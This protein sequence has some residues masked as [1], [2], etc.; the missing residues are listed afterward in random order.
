MLSVCISIICFKGWWFTTAN[1]FNYSKI[2]N[3][4]NTKCCKYMLV[5]VCI[6]SSVMHTQL[7]TGGLLSTVTQLSARSH[8]CHS[9]SADAWLCLCWHPRPRKIVRFPPALVHVADHNLH[10]YLP[11]LTR[12][13]HQL[14]KHSHVLN[15]PCASL[16][17]LK[18][19]IIIIIVV[20][21]I[22]MVM[23][24]WNFT[25]QLNLINMNVGNTS[26]YRVN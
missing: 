9:P 11:S 17:R 13:T 19:N 7:Q 4:N 15:T 6:H 24:T 16:C 1:T 22:L 18:W 10:V 20:V 26:H 12:W 5:V 25:S 8:D 14:Y 23:I 3:S 2:C 21:I